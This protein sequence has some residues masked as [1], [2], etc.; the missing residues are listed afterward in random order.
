MKLLIYSILLVSRIR[1]QLCAGTCVSLGASRDSIQINAHPSLVALPFEAVREGEKEEAV[2]VKE[3]AILKLGEL[4]ARN[5]FAEGEIWT[6]T[7][8]IY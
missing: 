6:A 2:K 1:S 5:G 4:F 3:L 8:P 7:W